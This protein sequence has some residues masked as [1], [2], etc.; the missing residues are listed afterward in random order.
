MSETYPRKPL[1]IK[2]YGHIGHLPGSRMGPGDHT[3]PDGHNLIATAKPR[4]KHDEVFVQEKLDGSN[5]GVALL[6]G[7]LFALTRAGYVAFSSPW[8]QHHQFGKWVLKNTERFRA[9]L[10]EGERLCGEWLM[11]AHGTRY[12]LPHE[13]FV[14]FDLMTGTD[15]A[16]YDEFITRIAPGKFVVPHLIHRGKPLGIDAAM[17]ALGAKGFHGASEPVEGAV[18]RVER[19]HLIGRNTG[20]RPIPPSDLRS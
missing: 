2:N 14:A 20:E 6:N 13:P 10:K 8:P 5:V 17:R 1:G 15:R 16:I 18:W 4:D 9:V 3:C 19:N 12:D 7:E 11:Q